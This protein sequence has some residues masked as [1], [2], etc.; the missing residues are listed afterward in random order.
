[1]LFGWQG[2][3]GPP[4]A[5]SLRAVLD[6]VFAAP[7]YHWVERPSPLA[8]FR[9]WVAAVQQWLFDLKEAHPT[10][11]RLFL[12]AMVLV[13]VATF[14]HAAW[15]FFRTVQAGR[16]TGDGG[17]PQPA[18]ERRDQG[19]YRRQADRLAGEGRYAEA[20]QHDFLALVL[21]LDARAL[22]RFHPSKTPAEYGREARLGPG[23]SEEFRALIRAVYAFAFAR[24][25]CGPEEFA[26][27]RARALPERYAPAQ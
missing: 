8:F 4:G 25:P 27:W 12:I 17:S 10:W 11:Y 3:G 1:M 21:A 23:A 15:V 14:L 26:A 9:R 2:G 20:I 19:W 6:S 18:G 5:D 13:V 16:H 7:A 24:R 22:L